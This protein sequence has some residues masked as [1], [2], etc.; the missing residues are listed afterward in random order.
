M[1]LPPLILSSIY[2][3][4]NLYEDATQVASDSVG[5]IRTIASFCAEEKVIELYQQK[6]ASPVRLGINHGLLSGAGFGMAAFFLYSVY[7]ASYYAGARLVHSGNITFEE[8]FRVR[9]YPSTFFLYYSLG[10]I[11]LVPLDEY[12]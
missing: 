2:F 9:F 12:M 8:V 5:N 7:A 4:Q 3:K 10:P 1:T 11:I 6:C